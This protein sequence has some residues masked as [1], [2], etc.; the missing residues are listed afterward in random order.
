M[1]TFSG[2]WGGGVC[3]RMQVGVCVCVVTIGLRGLV[4]GGNRGVLFIAPLYSN[5]GNALV[6][7]LGKTWHGAW[8]IMHVSPSDWPPINLHV[9]RQ[10]AP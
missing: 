9:G 8:L 3:A 2:C 5:L 6:S 4:T 7:R 10:N 1:R